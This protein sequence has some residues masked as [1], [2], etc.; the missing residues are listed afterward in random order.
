MIIMSEF[1]IG[2]LEMSNG[3]AKSIEDFEDSTILL[4]GDN[5][6]LI[7]LVNPDKESLGIIMENTSS[8]WPVSVEV[9]CVKESVSLLEEEM[10]IDQL[11]LVCLAHALK[12]VEFTLKVSFEGVTGCDNLVHNLKSLSFADT[13]S[14]RIASEISADSDSCGVDHSSLILGEIS[15][16]K[17]ISSH[18]RD[19]LIIFSMLVVVLN[20]LVENLGELGISIVRSGIETDTR[21]LVGNTRENA[22]LESYTFFAGLVLILIPDLFC[23]AYFSLRFG[24][25]L[26]ELVKVDEVLGALVSLVEIELGFLGGLR[27][28]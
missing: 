5:S 22:G 2:G 3:S 1:D 4:H 6:E 18:V 14:K 17:T 21:V 23:K 12:W 19:V 7:F 15:V 28:A 25:F 8:R 26:K 27:N 24:S 13:W 10:I 20:N 9:A 16:F 11:V